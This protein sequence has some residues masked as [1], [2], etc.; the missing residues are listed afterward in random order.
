MGLCVGVVLVAAKE[1]VVESIQQEETM[2]LNRNPE[3]PGWFN[4]DLAH[5]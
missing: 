4:R 2:N 3:N 5:G 1:T